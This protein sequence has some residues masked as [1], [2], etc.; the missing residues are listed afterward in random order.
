MLAALILFSTPKFLSYLLGLLI[1]VIV[2]YEFRVKEARV[3]AEI[4]TEV[5]EKWLALA[6]AAKG[7]E[8]A[9]R[10]EVVKTYDWFNDLLHK[11]KL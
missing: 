6:S 1:A 3:L 4:E 8:A 2:G 11:I 10:A 5:T 9:L 7:D